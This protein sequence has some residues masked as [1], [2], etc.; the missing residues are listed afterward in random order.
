MAVQVKIAAFFLLVMFP[1]VKMQDDF[2]IEEEKIFFEKNETKNSTLFQ[3]VNIEFDGQLSDEWKNVLLDIQKDA[4]NIPKSEGLVTNLRDDEKEVAGGSGLTQ[5]TA[6]G[7]VGNLDFRGQD[8][9][10]SITCRISKRRILRTSNNQPCRCCVICTYFGR[11]F[12]VRQCP[13]N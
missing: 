5:N 2:I 12:S 11:I 13:R 4:E 8:V 9:D 1:E 6:I 3:F 7:G 10:I